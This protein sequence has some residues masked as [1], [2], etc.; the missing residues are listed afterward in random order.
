MPDNKTTKKILWLSL[1]ALGVVYGDLGTSPLYALQL[2]VHH[3][4]LTQNNVLGILSLIFWA[5]VLVISTRYVSVFL[6]ADNDGEGGVLALVSLL[7]RG[8]FTKFLYFLGIL[9]AGLLL[10]DGMLTPAISVIS[11]VEGLKVISPTFEHLIM[12]ISFV[13]LFVLFSCQR[14]GTGKIGFLFGPI[15][16]LWFI[17]IAILG[18]SAIIR[19]PVVL[20][21]ANPYYAFE[22]FY[23]GGWR[24]Y[25]LLSSIFLVITGAEAMYADLGHFGR[26]PIR[27]GWFCVA[28]PALLL[29]YFGQGA[30]L[31]QSP[32][33]A[34]ANTFYSLAP[35][36][37]QYP[38][39][40][41]ATVATVIASQ[42]V[43]T[44][45]FSLAKQ[46][47]LLNVSPRLTIVQTSEEEKGQVYVPQ[48]NYIL[49]FGTLLLVAI[50]QSSDSLAAAFGMAVNL[51]MIIVA[52]LVMYVAR[53][54][55]KWSRGKI[56]RVFFLFMIIDFAFLGAN[57]HKIHQGGWIPLLFATLSGIIMITW[58]QGMVLLRSSYYMNKGTLPDI[59]HELDR[60][61]LNYIKDSTA[62]FLTDPY[63]QSGGSF[64]H[65]LK[66]FRILPEQV[67]IV[68][69]KI[70]DYPYLTE[71]K[72][73]ETNKL[74]SGIYRVILH[75]GFMQTIDVPKAL[76]KCG[77]SKIFTIP[78]D[79]NRS[80]FLVERITVN[81]VKKKYRHFFYWQKKL[82]A[83]LLRNSA[84][85]IEFFHLPYNR[86]IM[87]GSYCN[88]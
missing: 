51:V 41:L 32:T 49:A 69:I 87:I 14:F 15:L 80:S 76:M 9:G 74:C 59:I 82:F 61:Q 83:Y 56:V 29:N 16:L 45:S 36:W 86:T 2:T 75:F 73:Y 26:T 68:S 54:Y 66:L 3:V 55:W 13:I 78:F 21:A 88:I 38:L 50:F 17:T 48:I 6:R 10:G 53:Q 4:S 1:G 44:A 19:N 24:A 65:Y 39:L 25:L 57:F 37:F 72:R 5:L 64:L 35:S 12:P 46:A 22:F 77:K 23:H 30:N 62:V 63:D 60:S 8:K 34:L 81:V 20:S 7:K 85:D 47:I 40:I 31:L 84:L 33:A 71:A 52:M 28:L 67:L 42:C 18:A 79:V 11:A 70:E 27:I 58:S 43:I